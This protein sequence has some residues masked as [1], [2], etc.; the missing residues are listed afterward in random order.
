MGKKSSPAEQGSGKNDGESGEMFF[1]LTET[2]QRFLF[3][4]LAASGPESTPVSSRTT[5]PVS[6]RR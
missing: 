3:S 5:R 6:S 2:G 4:G 1:T